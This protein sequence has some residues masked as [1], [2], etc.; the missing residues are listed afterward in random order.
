[1]EIEGMIIQDLG[2]VDGTSKTGNPWKKHEWLMETPGQYPR[3]VKFDVWGDRA[4]SMK[5]EV[6]KFYS[7]SVDV[8]SRQFNDRW[9][10][11]VK[12]FSSRQVEGPQGG[13][14]QPA[15]MPQVSAPQ[16]GQSNPF[17]SQPGYSQPAQ[18]AEGAFGGAP[19]FAAGGN[20]EED[21]PF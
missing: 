2:Q 20:A 5:F 1:M 18:P 14:G 13:L 12:A 6:G 3:K 16:P 7:V 17:T 21:L 10:T 11:D 4:E 19:D 8:E 9:Y 15:G